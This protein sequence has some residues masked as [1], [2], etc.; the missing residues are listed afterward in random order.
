MN[1]KTTKQTNIQKKPSRIEFLCWN[2]KR[3]AVKGL[4]LNMTLL[5]HNELIHCGSVQRLQKTGP[6][7][8]L[9]WLKYD[10]MRLTH[11]PETLQIIN[12]CQERRS[13]SHQWSSHLLVA[14]VCV[15]NLP[16]MLMQLTLKN[17]VVPNKGKKV[18]R[19]LLRIKGGS[20]EGE[21]VR[22]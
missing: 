7:N 8:I 3:N 5:L 11:F 20:M 15:S 13:H 17:V 16:P 4:L 14:L 10:F 6:I 9:S 2:M 21:W 19:E 12:C 22:E 1:Q 18:K